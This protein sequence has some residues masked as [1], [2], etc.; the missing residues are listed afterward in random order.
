MFLIESNFTILQSSCVSGEPSSQ[1]LSDDTAYPAVS[2][3][4]LDP[5]PRI[6]HHDAL[7][8]QNF[9]IKLW[10]ECGY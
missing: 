1:Y 5:Q 9:I 7:N 3:S 10:R 4:R 8:L 6:L 2:G